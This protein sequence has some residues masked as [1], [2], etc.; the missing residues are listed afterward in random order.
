LNAPL[1]R[2]ALCLLLI[3]SFVISAQAEPKVP[4]LERFQK[5]KKVK[6]FHAGRLLVEELNCVA[7][8]ESPESLSPKSAPV[9]SEVSGRVKASYL[10]KF[11]ANPG[12]VK[13]GTTMPN[14]F[15]STSAK[16][17]DDQVEA[18]VHFLY[19][20]GPGEPPQTYGRYGAGE[21]GEKLFHSVGCVGCHDPQ[22]KE[23]ADSIPLGDLP[24]KYTLASLSK[25]LLNPLHVRK[26]GRMPSLNLSSTE[27]GDIASYLLPDVPQKAGISFEHYKADLNRLPDFSKLEPTK[28]GVATEFNVQNGSG[29]KFAL[30]YAGQFEVAESAKYEFT[31]GSDDGSKLLIDGKVVVNNDGVHGMS[32]KKGSVELDAGRHDVVVEFFEQGGGEELEVLFSAPGIDKQRLD[33]S[34]VASAPE[35]P[36]EDLSFKVDTELATK[37][38][39]LFASLGCAACHEVGEPL[40][41]ELDAPSLAKMDGTKGCLADQPT[42]GMNYALSEPQRVAL[43]AV[44]SDGM[45]P[46]NAKREVL[47]TMMKFNCVACH[48][49]DKIGGV[50]V[51]RTEYFKTTQQEMGM[52]GSIPPHLDGVG[53]K[54]TR[55]WLDKIL[56]KGAKDRPYMLTRMPKFG[57]D[58]VGH[59]AEKLEKLDTLEPLDKLEVDALAAKKAGHKMVG[60]KGFSC[61]KCHTF[62][63][64]KATGVQSIDMTIMH[65]RLR[66]DWFRSY[67][68]NPPAY[69]RGTRMPSAWP[70]SG[71]SFLPDLLDGD[72]DKQIAAV[73]RYLKDGNRAKTPY[74]L[75]SSSKELIPT[76]EAIIYRNFIAG[77]G[78]RAI[79]VGYPE[80]VH[81]AFDANDLRIA[82]IWQGAFIDASRHWNGRGQGYQPPAGEN[83]KQLPP[84]ISIAALSSADAAWPTLEGKKGPGPKFLARA[85]GHQFKGYRL[86]PD[87]RPTFL[88]EIDGL[89]VEDFPNPSE[90]ATSVSLKRTLT[91]SGSPKSNTFFRLAVGSITRDGDKFDLGEG[92]TL[93][94]A[95]AES[96]SATVRE[97]G[98]SQEL[99]VPIIKEKTKIELDYSW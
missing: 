19:S 94:V 81:L 80:G 90:T 72:S 61:I 9:L 34:M 93:H 97:S 74:G 17:R 73:W 27:A 69:R 13:P 82:L 38:K 14:V 64:H 1:C 23:L 30:R 36:L 91:I 53:G 87:Q 46:L 95:D 37:G 50:D 12:D 88:Y 29:D 7:C 79:G 42:A 48:A 25:F 96:L 89:K 39:K 33:Q 60:A 99:L 11:I 15:A 77:A 65:K 41:S 63:R 92:L 40:K 78:S 47:H 31:L 49:R 85:M 57:T 76:E 59:L 62:G 44:A 58:N 16:D 32:R 10:R 26:S 68:K 3:F 21:R 83:V 35:T 52:E 56:A 18:L 45:K 70:P 8:H 6:N 51:A 22:G 4:S 54:L 5:K 86:T 55:A 43:R 84:S 66:E 20:T 24:S 98:G 2:S 75:S 28:T 71:P 67:V